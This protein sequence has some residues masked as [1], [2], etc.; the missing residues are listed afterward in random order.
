M[1]V[2]FAKELS[3]QVLKF[4]NFYPWNGNLFFTRI[5]SEKHSAK[6]Y[7]GTKWGIN[8]AK[9]TVSLLWEGR[10]KRIYVP[11]PFIELH[12]T[13]LQLWCCRCLMISLMLPKTR[14][15]LCIF[16]T[17]LWGNRGIFYL[18]PQV[19]PSS[20]LLIV[21]FC[22]FLF[23]QSSIS[24]YSSL[25]ISTWSASRNDVFKLPFILKKDLLSLLQGAGWWSHS[26]GL[27][28]IFKTS[29]AGAGPGSSYLLVLFFHI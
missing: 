26:L 5:F 13:L 15:S 7:S 2:A 10:N 18:S 19:L 9:L 23:C 29:W 12:N 1:W 24:P 3:E 14:S 25:F 16:G 8:A 4:E 28:G 11:F 27:W 17:H 20:S 22:S 21:L 6:S